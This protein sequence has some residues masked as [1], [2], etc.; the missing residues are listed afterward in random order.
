VVFLAVLFCFFVLPAEQYRIGDIRYELMG[1]TKAYALGL[2]VEV[3]QKRVFDSLVDLDIY[4]AKIR[5]ELVNQ[6]VFDVAEIVYELPQNDGNADSGT[7]ATPIPVMIT[8][9]ARDTFNFIV[10]PYPKY[11]SNS[12]WDIKLKLKDYNFLGLM[13]TLTADLVYQYTDES[14]NKIGF[15]LDY[16]FPFKLSPF[17]A[18]WLNSVSFSYTIGESEPEYGWTTGLKLVFPLD[19]IDL[20]F[21][22][23]HGLSRNFDYDWDNW[24]NADNKQYNDGFYFTDSAKFAVPIALTEFVG[25]SRVYFTPDVHFSYNW[26]PTDG[27]IKHP[28]LRGP[29][30]GTGYS[31]STSHIDWIGNYRKGFSLS[32]GQ[33]LD[34]SFND[35][36]EDKIVPSVSIALS[37]FGAFKYASI[38][39]RINLFSYFLADSATAEM[40]GLNSKLIG[41]Y[42]RGVKDDQRGSRTPAAFVLNGDLPVKV[43]STNWRGW[44]KTVTRHTAPGWFRFFDF[45]LQASPFFD[46]ALTRNTLDSTDHKPRDFSLKDGWYSAGME[47]LIF[48]ARWRSLVVRVSGG[49]DLTRFGPSSKILNKVIKPDMDWRESVSK[50]ELFFGIGLFY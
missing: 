37:G 15:N 5:R 28:D 32:A 29:V 10:I 7:S 31:L 27:V 47:F 8:I 19:V 39:A 48:P 35:T 16:S 13:Q 24:N 44:W 42:L 9:M 22:V 2:A 11:D 49:V 4:V 36:V 18:Q 20:E 26:D 3:D 1:R 40:S 50:Y 38:S 21:T 25:V 41:T 34:Y 14:E 30:L 6:R 46:M 33:S 17:D 12:G 43:V 45:E 23:E